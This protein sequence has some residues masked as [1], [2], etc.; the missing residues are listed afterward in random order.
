MRGEDLAQR[1]GRVLAARAQPSHLERA[2]NALEQRGVLGRRRGRLRRSGGRARRRRALGRRAAQAL[3]LLLQPRA[4]ARLGVARARAFALAPLQFF[5]HAAALVAARGG[6]GAA[7]LA[8]AQ[9]RVERRARLGVEEEVVRAL[10]RGKLVGSMRVVGVLVGV[11]LEREPAVGLR[12]E[13]RRRAAVRAR[14][15]AAACGARRRRAGAARSVK[16]ANLL[17]LRIRAL[18]ALLQPEEFVGVELGRVH[19]GR[20]GA[21][22]GRVGAALE[23]PG[24]DARDL[25]GHWDFLH[26]F[27]AR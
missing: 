10:E 23:A 12:E 27:R 21:G 5:H 6:G 20:G 1:R 9:E 8:R 19:R 7:R 11:F 24:R 15:R 22:A 4:R 18:W 25:P 26:F 3:D 17:D 2:A 14:R 16:R 13:G